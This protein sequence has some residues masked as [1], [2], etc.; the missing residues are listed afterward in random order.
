VEP[1]TWGI[2]DVA[3]KLRAKLQWAQDHG[4]Y[5]EIHDPKAAPYVVPVST[6]LRAAL[7]ALPKTS[8]YVFAQHA[9]TPK[10]RPSVAKVTQM[11][12]FGCYAAGIR[13]GRPGG[14]TWH[15]LRHTG[16]TR[17]LGAGASVRDLM[18]LGG[19][20]DMKSMA[21]YTRP[22]GVDRALVDRMS[23]A[24]S[25]HG[26]GSHRQKRSKIA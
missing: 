14:L 20:R 22:T 4:D 3:R 12:R 15:A 26:S 7:D 17:A 21:R 9:R 18:A 2:G 5:L 11:F 8:P 10:G 16:A 25:V 24:R 23:R 1:L 6:R 13:Y 19:W